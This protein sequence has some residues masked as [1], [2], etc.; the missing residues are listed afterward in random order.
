MIN[1]LRNSAVGCR[2]RGCVPAVL[3][4]GNTVAW[5]DA[6]EAYIIKDGANLVSQMTDR[7]G[8]GHHLPQ[9]GV[10]AIKPV[11]S[12]DGVLFDGVEDY[13]K[14]AAFTLIQP[15][16]IYM[17][18]KQVTWALNDYIMDGQASNSGFLAQSPTTPYIK[19]SAG[20]S[21]SANT[22]LA[23]NTWGIARVLFNGASSKFIINETTPITGNFGAAN[24]GGFTLG[25]RGNPNIAFSNI[26]VKE[27]IIR[28]IADTAPNE[29]VIYNYLESRYGL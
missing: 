19:V 9:A 4:D 21:S 18:F 16:F 12:V 8:L 14:T 23:V 1:L 17:V 15:E 5:F 10:D 13:M 26:Q 27:V 24:M 25:A 7:T 3:S 6:D 11:W 29:A 22:N 20:T 28:K 2:R